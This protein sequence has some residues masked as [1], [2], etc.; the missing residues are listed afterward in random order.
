MRRFIHIAM[1][2]LALTLWI[3]ADCGT[4]SAFGK[5]GGGRGRGSGGRGGGG[6]RTVAASGHAHGGKPTARHVQKSAAQGD[7]HAGGFRNSQ[8]PK[9]EDHKQTRHTDRIASDRGALDGDHPWST[10]R[11][12]EERKLNHRLG[13]ADK[14]ERLAD[15]NGN[16]NLRNT[17]ERMRQKAHEHYDKRIAKIDSKQPGNGEAD[18][19]P[20]KLPADGQ[21]LSELASQTPADAL[22][23]AS[24]A[25]PIAGQK[26]TG[27]QNALSRQLLNEE[28]K[29]AHQTELA[30]RLRALAE[31]QGDAALLQTADRLEQQA[32]D[33][34]ENRMDAI[35]NF[36]ERHG[37]ALEELK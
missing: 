24:R 16:E 5:G 19:L 35:G 2:T 8:L 23:N 27:P 10:Q 25:T 4:A 32:L 20:Y 7:A 29:L 30:E 18:A 34:F 14:L 9:R 33:R 17:A 11:A 6:N 13:V 3:I 12:N 28:R 36:Q 1:V 22:V 21:P 37:L 31:E 15:S 26:L